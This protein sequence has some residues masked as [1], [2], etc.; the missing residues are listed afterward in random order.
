MS[1]A[2]PHAYML[3]GARLKATV[4]LLLL[5]LLQGEQALSAAAASQ[6]S[7]PPSLQAGDALDLVQPPPPKPADATNA[8]HTPHTPDAPNGAPGSAL[9]EGAHLAHRAAHL[10]TRA[11]LRACCALRVDNVGADLPVLV[12]QLC[13]GVAAGVA[14]AK[15]VHALAAQTCSSSTGTSQHSMGQRGQGDGQSV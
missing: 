7:T 1:T 9:V 12:T 14:T 6:A 10:C 8:P 3:A 13:E 5:L 11:P 15:L 4:T 2:T